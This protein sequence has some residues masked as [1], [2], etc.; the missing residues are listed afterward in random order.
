MKYVVLLIQLVELF[1]ALIITFGGEY[2][3]GILAPFI[4]FI[5][6]FLVNTFLIFRNVPAHNKIIKIF[7]IITG[8]VLLATLVWVLYS[9]HNYF[10]ENWKGMSIAE[11]KYTILLIS[12]S[13]FLQV[14]KIVIM[15]KAVSLK[16]SDRSRK[17]IKYV[18]LSPVIALVIYFVFSSVLFT[19]LSLFECGNDEYQTFV[20]PNG[21]HTAQLYRRNCG[22]TTDYSGSVNL[23]GKEIFNL[24]HYYDNIRVSWANDDNL[25]VE[26]TYRE[27]PDDVSIKE[28]KYKGVDVE[29]FYW[30]C[31]GPASKWPEGFCLE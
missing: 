6:L 4:L 17:M 31:I 15:R 9:G 18:L 11:Y 5:V 21:A 27:S 28:A 14:A 30:P 29:Y 3:E 26:Y 22:A 16:V 20:S 24:Y 2:P 25:L 8:T 13:M 23:D 10:L 12:I 1:V 19:G 7:S